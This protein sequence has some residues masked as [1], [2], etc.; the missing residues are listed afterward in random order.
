MCL[1]VPAVIYVVLFVDK[2]VIQ[3]PVEVSTVESEVDFHA[4]LGPADEEHEKALE[5]QKEHVH[6]CQ[7]PHDHH[8]D[9]DE[10]IRVSLEGTVF[11]CL[12]LQ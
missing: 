7:E 10:T 12:V 2:D 6:I 3:A 11:V 9:K 1:S 5:Q 8:E 4:L